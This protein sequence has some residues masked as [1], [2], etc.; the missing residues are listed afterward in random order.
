MEDIGPMVASI[1]MYAAIRGARSGVLDA[2]LRDHVAACATCR[3]V[4]EVASSLRSLAAADAASLSVPAPG[5]TFWRAELA[6][7]RA[8]ER[9]AL[10]A[11]R[12]AELV[13]PAVSVAALGVLAVAYRAQI[14]SWISGIFSSA[15]KAAGPE[16]L[17]AALITLV[18]AAVTV[19][20]AAL[21]LRPFLAGD[22][23]D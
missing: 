1:A 9:R 6:K 3:E 22:G 12:V 7:R 19:T 21:A 16:A 18:A 17:P 5:R 15:P 10:S 20:V 13:G 23:A 2:S 8:A 14:G 11:V 4:H